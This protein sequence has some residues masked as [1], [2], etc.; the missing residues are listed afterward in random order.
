MKEY[1]VDIERIEWGYV[2]VKAK[3]RED[4]IDKGWKALEEGNILWNKEDIREIDAS[5]RYIP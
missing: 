4:A 1:K 3:N 5:E 2:L